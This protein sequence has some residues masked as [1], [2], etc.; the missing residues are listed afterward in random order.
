MRG[1]APGAQT[2]AGTSNRQGPARLPIFTST[3]RS[4]LRPQ[5]GA[6]ARR[7]LR[8]AGLLSMA[9]YGLCIALPLR[10]DRHPSSRD[11]R[12]AIALGEAPAGLVRFITVMVAL[13]ALY[14]V[15]VLAARR[16]SDRDAPV[17]LAVCALAA[18]PFYSYDVYHYAASAGV[19][20]AHHSNPLLMPPS[21][22]TGDAIAALSDRPDL[23]SPYGPVWALLTGLPSLQGEARS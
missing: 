16:L 14:M 19:L 21:A 4:C 8:I 18:H 3:P 10:L 2:G 23:P 12:L 22:F 20:W 5:N 13:F 7:T 11:F 15:A 6:W 9:V 17:A 1:R